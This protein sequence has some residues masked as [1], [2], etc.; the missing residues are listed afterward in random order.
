MRSL[1]L[2]EVNKLSDE[3]LIDNVAFNLQFRRALGRSS[4]ETPVFS[5]RTLTRIRTRLTSY[6]LDEYESYATNFL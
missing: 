3:E 5:N 1:I 2:K 6:K 4:L